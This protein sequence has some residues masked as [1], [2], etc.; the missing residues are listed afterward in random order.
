MYQSKKMEIS[1][2][3]VAQN[4]IVDLDRENE[5][6]CFTVN[7]KKAGAALCLLVKALSKQEKHF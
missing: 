5:M 1:C 3:F 6:F 2:A 4:Y 7:Y